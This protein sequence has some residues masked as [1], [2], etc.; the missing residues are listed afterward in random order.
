MVN[1]V[2][3]GL[4]EL[5]LEDYCMYLH[6]TAPEILSGSGALSKAADVFS[7][8]MVMVDVRRGCLVWISC[9]LISSSLP[10]T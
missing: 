8:A 7:F 4:T 1:L 9:L 6:Y 2:A 10:P 3:V 5:K